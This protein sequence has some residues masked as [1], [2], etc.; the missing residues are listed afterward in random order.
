[1]CTIKMTHEYNTQGKKD[2]AVTTNSLKSLE[3]NVI[4]NSK[5]AL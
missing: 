4:S 2:I 1:M 5:G 3:D